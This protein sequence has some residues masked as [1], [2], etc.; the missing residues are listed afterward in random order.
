MVGS[1]Q[2]LVP[3]EGRLGWLACL[4]SI[5]AK[6]TGPLGWGV[7]DFLIWRTGSQIG[8]ST[9]I[10]W[11]RHDENPDVWV[12][13]EIIQYVWDASQAFQIYPQMISEHT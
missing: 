7:V 4:G 6:T 2:Q 8:L 1:S 5:Q 12:L 10:T 13:L 9:R 11:G 3:S